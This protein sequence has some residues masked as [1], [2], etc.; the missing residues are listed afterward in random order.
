MKSSNHCILILGASGF[1]G[2]H[3]LRCA[4]YNNLRVR[5]VTRRNI[6]L[7]FHPLLDVVCADLSCTTDW[8]SVL[9]GVT[10]VVNCAGETRNESS[11][12][13]T[14]LFGPLNLFQAAANKG[15]HRWIQLSSVGAYGP[16]RTGDV[17]EQ[18]P[19]NPV[20]TYELSKSLFD[21]IVLRL[22]SSSPS[23]LDVCIIR[24]S[25]VY[26]L[27]MTNSSL[28]QLVHSIRDRCFFFVG[29]VQSS[30]NYIHVDDVVQ[31]I[32]C[33]LF[34]SQASNQVYIV[35]AWSTFDKMV[36]SISHALLV[37]SPSIRIPYR[38][39]RLISF[40]LRLIPSSP[41]TDSRIQAMTVTT[42]YLT[43]KIEAHL[44]WRV[45]KSV[46]EGVSEFAK[47]HALL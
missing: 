30:A 36:K 31:A 34:S 17:T 23:S 24:P 41:L 5:V 46:C 3:F 18:T 1:I 25:N 47:L 29:S 2:S 43:T 9:S 22:S 16:L 40:C 10:V 42:R 33:A 26:G 15:V 12:Y 28:S 14:N 19:D 39:A 38:L 32:I 21:Q 35:S 8:S 20:G 13:Q 7:G 6:S 44:N 37:S 27:D 45:S 4:L 11:M